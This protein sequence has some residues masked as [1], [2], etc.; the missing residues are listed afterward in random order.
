MFSYA[1][2]NVNITLRFLEKGHTQNEGDSIHA[3]IE[4]RVKGQKVYIP[5]DW[6]EIIKSA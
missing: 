3:T 5:N 2:Q 4:R 6:H 1:S